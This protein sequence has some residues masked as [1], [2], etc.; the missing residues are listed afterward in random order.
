[1]TRI[2]T[3]RLLA[4]LL[5]LAPWPGSAHAESSELLAAYH[6]YADL[7]AEGRYDDALPF[8][9]EALRLGEAELRPDHPTNAALLSNL[10]QLYHHQR[11]PRRCRAA[12]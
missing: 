2:V 7:D 1:M 8:A 12:V 11:P 3:N 5:C 10:A 9:E 4:A 6:R